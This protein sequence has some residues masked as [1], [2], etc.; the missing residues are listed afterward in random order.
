MPLPFFPKVP[1][2]RLNFDGLMDSI[3]AHP[4]AENEFLGMS[5]KYHADAESFPLPDYSRM[6]K[7][8]LAVS[9]AKDSFIK[10]SRDFDRKALMSAANVTFWEVQDMDHYVRKR[11]DVIERSFRWLATQLTREYELS[12]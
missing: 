9:G 8:F 4:S 7:P 3:S 2:T 5:Y 10:S 12:H 6:Q 1:R 11:P